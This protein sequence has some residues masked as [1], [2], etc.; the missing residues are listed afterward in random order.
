M[1]QAEKAGEDAEVM[2]VVVWLFNQA[3]GRSEYK[4]W[5][6]LECL[7][8]LSLTFSRL[9]TQDVR[10]NFKHGPHG[11]SKQH[12]MINFRIYHE[13][14]QARACLVGHHGEGLKHVICETPLASYLTSE[15]QLH[16]Y[17][18]HFSPFLS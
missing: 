9:W 12:S 11:Y 8:V 14:L 6:I 3:S 13:S 10:L 2:G 7:P 1:V 16:I 15:G 4:R 17:C 18:Y 5:L